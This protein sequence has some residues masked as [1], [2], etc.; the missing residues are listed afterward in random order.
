MKDCR[1]T[2]DPKKSRS[3]ACGKAPG[4]GKGLGS[5]VFID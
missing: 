2:E 3:L 1:Q 4:K 5:F